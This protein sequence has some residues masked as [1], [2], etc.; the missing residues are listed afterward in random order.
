MD[1]Q[2]SIMDSPSSPSH[3][4]RG[5]LLETAVSCSWVHTR[6]GDGTYKVSATAHGDQQLL[7]LCAAQGL[8][9]QGTTWVRAAPCFLRK[10]IHRLKQAP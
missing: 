3:L 4:D 5:T 2:I 7:V 1:A 8:D 9:R 6:K 10:A